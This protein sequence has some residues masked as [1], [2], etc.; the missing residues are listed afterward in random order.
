[1]QKVAQRL[2]LAVHEVG[3]EGI[4]MAGPADIEVIIYIY[5]YLYIYIVSTYLYIYI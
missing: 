1:M 4:E 3:S 5:M 2:N